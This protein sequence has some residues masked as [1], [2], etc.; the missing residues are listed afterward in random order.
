MALIM[1]LKQQAAT[2]KLKL[3]LKTLDAAAQSPRPLVKKTPNLAI[4]KSR[5]AARRS[6]RI[7]HCH[8]YPVAMVA[9]RPRL[10]GFL[11]FLMVVITMTIWTARHSQ[12][13]ERANQSIFGRSYSKAINGAVGLGSGLN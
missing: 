7:Q 2:E 4:R 1:P 6:D 12:G 11:M 10:G 8:S 13:P 5:A 3:K 9:G